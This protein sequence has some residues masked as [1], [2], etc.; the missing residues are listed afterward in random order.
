[1]KIICRTGLASL[2]VLAL[3]YPAGAT[4]PSE[5]VLYSFKGNK[6]GGMPYAGLITDKQ[7]ALYVSLR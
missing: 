6:A 4:T 7:G 5:A 3:Q 2:I 1:M